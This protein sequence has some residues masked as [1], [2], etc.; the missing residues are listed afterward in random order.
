[1][2]SH[3]IEDYNYIIVFVTSTP[4]RIAQEWCLAC[5]EALGFVAGRLP[6][7]DREAHRPLLHQLA[8]VAARSRNPKY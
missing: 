3:W 8:R 6:T 2:D 5:R 1:M 7:S 4:F